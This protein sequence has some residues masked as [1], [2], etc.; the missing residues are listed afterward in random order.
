MI[1]GKDDKEKTGTRSVFGIDDPCWELILLQSRLDRQRELLTISDAWCVLFG[2][3][4]FVMSPVFWLLS[5]SARPSCR[6]CLL[7]PPTAALHQP[8]F[9]LTLS[10]LA[11]LETANY[12]LCNGAEVDPDASHSS[13]VQFVFSFIDHQWL[14]RALD[15]VSWSGTDGEGESRTGWDGNE[16]SK[17]RMRESHAWKQR[18]TIW[19]WVSETVV[20]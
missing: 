19:Q 9:G 18:R 3:G 1:T 2:R 8:W 12:R 17:R 7:R 6:P 4:V 10:S 5:C 20:S 14:T 13:K 16:R 11:G 15:E